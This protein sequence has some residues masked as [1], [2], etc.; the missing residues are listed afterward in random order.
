M[1]KLLSANLLRLKKSI[2]FWGC[3][4]LM[5][6][7]GVG[8][9][10]QRYWEQVAYAEFGQ[11][12]YLDAVLFRHGLLIGIVAA[13]FVPMFFGMEYS[14]GAI[15]NKMVVGHSR[16]SIYLSHLITSVVVALCAAAAYV[17]PVLAVGLF[18]Y[19]PPALEAGTLALL[20]LGTLVLLAAY[21]ALYTL[22]TM[23]CSRKSTAA[24]ICLLGMLALYIVSGN[25]EIPLM[26]PEY[27]NWVVTE[28]GEMIP[29][30]PNPRY[31]GG[32]ERVYEIGRVFR[33]EGVDTRHNPEFTLMELYQAYTD[34]HGMMDLTEDM[35]RYV[36]QE[37]LG[38]TEVPYGEHVID[39]GKPFERLTMV[40]AVKKYAGVDFDQVADTE[41]AKKLADEHHIEYE[42]RHTKGDI[43]SLF[44]EEFCEEKL[45][46]PTF[47][48]DHPIE[49]SPLTKKKPDKPDYVERFELF[50]TGREMANAYSELN[51]PID[52]RE[53]FRAQEAALAAG[54][55]E[56][57]TTDEDFLNALE[58]GMPPTGGIGYG[59][60]RLVMLLT[61]SPAIRDVLLFPT[62]KTLGGKDQ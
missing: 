30:D 32:M 41:A 52:Q 1:I 23:N 51:D 48:M 59:I 24:V 34:Y 6:L 54:D 55:E 17:L 10:L 26:H 62:M 33:N 38:T 50:I 40:D 45:I 11:L 29:G 25:V 21:C 53:R 60:D 2:L 57:N 7:L 22:V 35:Y 20:V 8:F 39:L 46:Q 28:A 36:A 31:V 13:V 14:D 44:F 18:I 9:T 37:V 61:N 3:I 16:L 19:E 27:L 4:I 43:L 42:T 15:R 47:I 12:S 56:A 58:I 5:L 49:I